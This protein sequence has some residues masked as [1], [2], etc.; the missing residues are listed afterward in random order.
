MPSLDA[1]LPAIANDV[2][3][4]AL[5]RLA[6]EIRAYGQPV[7]VTILPNTDRAWSLNSAVANG[8][9]PQDVAR[10]WAHVRS[11][12]HAVGAENSAWV[13][14]PKDP[15][16][17]ALVAPPPALVD[18]VLLNL[19]YDPAGLTDDPALIAEVQAAHPGTPLVIEVTVVRSDGQEAPW[20]AQL[21]AQVHAA[22][23]VAGLIYYDG[24]PGQAAQQ[25][26][27]S[28]DL[29]AVQALGNMVASTAG[30]SPS[31]TSVPTVGATAVPT[32]Q[33]TSGATPSPT[34]LPTPT[35]MPA[36]TG[37]PTALVPTTEET[38]LSALREDRGAS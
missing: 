12:F 38:A 36:P 2:H 35:T 24:L 20:L 19:T 26:A 6:Q 11:L 34:A 9:I 21:A 32:A 1:S 3:D 4:G 15:A 23:G 29:Q 10:D 18:L 8:G 16:H 27:F 30:A 17:D 13:W 14:A 7:F 25:T 28:P 22:P 31:A 33:P 5:T 37:T